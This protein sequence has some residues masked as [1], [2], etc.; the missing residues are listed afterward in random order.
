MA[1]PSAPS[2]RASLLAGLRTGGVRSASQPLQV[3]HTAA[4]TGS[5]N[6]PRFAS[7]THS[8]NHFLEENEDDDQLA[9]LAAQN[10]TFQHNHRQSTIPMTASAADGTMNMFQQQQQQLLLRQLAVQRAAMGAGAMYTGQDE[11][12]EMQA[13]MM[14]MELLKFQASLRVTV[15]GCAL[16]C[17]ER[18]RL[19]NKPNKLSS[20]RQSYSSK[21]NVNK[22]LF[23]GT[24]VG[25]LNP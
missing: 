7:A 4:P 23:A 20:T 2:N 14:Q 21:L 9:E 6:I 17:I 5:F 13:Q 12:A 25:V 24:F 22:R 19:F 1:A 16:I 3:P 15:I 11:Q 18:F 8:S 10:L